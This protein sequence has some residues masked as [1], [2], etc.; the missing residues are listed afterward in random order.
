MAV[1]PS[2][3]FTILLLRS[4]TFPPALILPESPQGCAETLHNTT[5]IRS[6]EILPNAGKRDHGSDSPREQGVAFFFKQWGG[7]SK[8]HGG[9]IL[10]GRQY[11][12]FPPT[13]RSEG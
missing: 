6:E 3:M 9:D 1:I 11:H 2:R 8:G 5:G 13:V 4:T 7:T 10:E 12:E